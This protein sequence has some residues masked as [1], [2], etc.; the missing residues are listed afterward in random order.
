MTDKI[1]SNR[2]T[3]SA[4]ISNPVSSPVVPAN[5]TAAPTLGTP[6]AKIVPSANPAAKKSVAKKSAEKKVAKK[7]PKKP[8]QKS[9]VKKATSKKTVSK[10]AF[11]KKSPAKKPSVKKSGALK[12]TSKSSSKSAATKF[13]KDILAG[14]GKDIQ[15]QLD[16]FSYSFDIQEN[17]KLITQTMETIMG[18]NSQIDQF[19]KETIETVKEGSE[20]VVKASS[21]AFKGFE[22][23]LKEVST[24]I[25]GTAEKNSDALQKIMSYNSLNDFAE[26]QNNL[27]QET[28]DEAVSNAAKLSELSV[29]I[30]SESLQPLN[31]YFTKTYKKASSKIAA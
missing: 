17:T 5:S 3:S 23:Y 27:A 4:P 16:N 20:A 11:V 25:Q 9:A 21:L 30:C 6:K 12:S 24:L 1:E 26:A 22:T 18:N 31:E 8:L 2:V 14:L 29:K 15:K 7:S 10:K 19:S 28:L 13:Q